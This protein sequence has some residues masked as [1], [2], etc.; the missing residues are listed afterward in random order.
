[1]LLRKQTFNRESGFTLL[2]LLVVILIIGLLT[3][4]VAPRFLGQINRSEI[5]AAKAQLEALDKALQAYR[6]DTGRYPSTAQG[7]GALLQQPAD[8]TR[9]RGPYLQGELPTDP[10]G[11]A[12]Q[13]RVPGAN[14]KDFELLS[15]GKDRAPGG[16]G[17]DAD[18]VR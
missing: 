5:T 3:G 11:S 1:M 2:E 6:I 15:L 10:W 16:Q 18:I 8:E 4:I 7:L 12:Y 14:N 17:D 13:Y 9:W